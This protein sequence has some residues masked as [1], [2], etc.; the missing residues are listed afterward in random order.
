[1]KN[2]SAFSVFP[3]TENSISSRRK[4][5]CKITLKKNKNKCDERE[6]DS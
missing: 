2:F 3:N 6:Y 4:N 5:L 1:M